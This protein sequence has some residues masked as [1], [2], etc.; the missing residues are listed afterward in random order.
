[1][2]LELSRDI[3]SIRPVRRFEAY[4][5][6]DLVSTSLFALLFDNTALWPFALYALS[7]LR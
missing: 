5:R 7:Q 4:D 3:S 1:M 6:I 2:S